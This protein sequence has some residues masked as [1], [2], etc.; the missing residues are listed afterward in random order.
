MLANIYKKIVTD[1]SKI[2]PCDEPVSVGMGLGNGDSTG[3]DLEL[4][5]NKE[6]CINRVLKTDCEPLNKKYLGE[7]Y[8]ITFSKNT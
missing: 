8:F 2:A 4:L 7:D 1:F 5:L 6:N 3:P